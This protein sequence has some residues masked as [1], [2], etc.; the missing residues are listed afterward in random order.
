MPAV[1]PKDIPPRRPLAKKTNVQRHLLEQQS[2]GK[3]KPS[4]NAKFQHRQ[5][6][7][8]QSQS[9]SQSNKA[10]NNA[11]NP[12][13]PLASIPVPVPVPVPHRGGPSSSSQQPSTPSSL[14]SSTSSLSS[15]RRLKLK[16][17]QQ[18][19]NQF[20]RRAASN[21]TSI[22]SLPKPSHK[23]PSSSNDF[24]G[25]LVSQDVFAGAFKKRNE[26]LRV[27]FPGMDRFEMERMDMWNHDSICTP[28]LIVQPKSNTE[29][30]DTLT[31]YTYGVL[32][33]L[34]N[35]KKRAASQPQLIIPR[36]TIAGGRNSISAMR[37]GCIVLDMSRMRGIKVYP[38]T[39]ECKIQ[40][41]VRVADLDA[42]LAEYGYIAI[43]S[44]FQNMG[45]V[46]CIL[47]G[48][49]GFG[50]AS[51][52]FGLACDNVLEAE[53]VLANG[54][55]KRCSKVRHSDLFF[56]LCGG[57]GGGG[58]GV[59]VSV[60]LR[61][62]PL[63]HAALLTYDIPSSYKGEN[64]MQR[65]RNVLN[66]W[67]RWVH[68]HDH[69]DNDENQVANVD[70]FKDHANLNERQQMQKQLQQQNNND[71]VGNEVFSQLIIPTKQSSSIQFIATSIDDQAIPQR[72]GFIEEY[73][74]AEKKSKRGILGGS[75]FAR[76]KNSGVGGI[77]N[78][79]SNT[80]TSFN[81]H[82]SSTDRMKQYG[83]DKMPHLSDLIHN[84]FN[85]STRSNVQ[86]RMARYADQLQ[87]HSGEYFKSGNVYVATKYC[88]ALTTKI[89][90]IIVQATLDAD[91]SPNNQSKIYLHSLGGA[92]GT[93]SSHSHTR[94][95]GDRVD[96]NHDIAFNARQMNYVIFIEGRWEAVAEH[97]Y[98][99]EK[100]KVTKWVN[101]VIN[102]LH[103]ADGVQSTSHPES[104][105]DQVPKRKAPPVGYY[106]FDENAGKKLDQIKK[107]RDPK[108]VFS[109]TSRVSW[110]QGSSNS[111]AASP[112]SLSSSSP[113]QS[114]SPRST[115]SNSVQS[116]KSGEIDPSH[117]LTPK[118]I[119]QPNLMETA[120][121]SLSNDDVEDDDEFEDSDSASKENS[122]KNEEH[123]VSDELNRL[124][125]MSDSDE[126][127]K[128]WSFSNNMDYDSIGENGSS[129]ASTEHESAF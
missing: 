104:V 95:Y 119:Q 74:E 68:G 23:P 63:L 108:N 86:F 60:T 37:D 9:Q 21:K 103:K 57:G 82:S 26:R 27:L 127:L 50:Y 91:V 14:Y 75:V 22:P 123:A 24:N 102:L 40:G 7:Q 105:R 62:Y 18:H 55:L 78:N 70:E 11:H 101:W 5:Q 36:L 64:M 126:D 107:R 3:S 88:R 42:T 110:L 39:Q 2:R 98:A 54:K 29:V 97:K 85:A 56:A 28:C 51:R 33:C 6:L 15:S 46:G 61:I 114:P 16:H 43:S 90:E 100:Q 94:K 20:H 32:K 19:S 12:P 4:H 111:D 49:C 38:Q 124:L 67:G 106:N 120:L 83:W 69:H 117:C 112:S 113:S 96:V 35:N 122:I 76:L 48:G 89:I 17:Q 8:K 58:I 80:T 34:S 47:S 84:K 125:T 1:S 116:V 93:S 129:S 59:V 44:V 99:K 81:Q 53:V 73:E 25:D 115:F 79:N 118:K 66:E 71:G 10:Q 52:K 30:T 65:R 128:H 121:E 72:D 87:S 31:G 13:L 92:I 109:L 45:V 41:G 77:G